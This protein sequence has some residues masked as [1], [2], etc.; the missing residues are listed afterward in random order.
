[1]QADED[2]EKYSDAATKLEK[3]YSVSPQD[4][5]FLYYAANDAIR[6]KDYANALDYLNTLKDIK[7]DGVETTYVAT[8]VET[9]KEV[10]GNV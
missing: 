5:S 1:M 9:K 7:Y 2:A 3:L 8:D 4:T 10:R 6:A